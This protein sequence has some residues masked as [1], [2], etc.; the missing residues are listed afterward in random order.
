[1]RAQRAQRETTRPTETLK[2]TTARRVFAA[3]D[4]HLTMFTSFCITTD[5]T[6]RFLPLLTGV[7]RRIEGKKKRR[8]R[9]RC[10]AWL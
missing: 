1:M 8:A 9:R 5:N 7:G 2:K 10:A 6:T 3:A 4:A